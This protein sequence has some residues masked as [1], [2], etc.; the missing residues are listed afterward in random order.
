MDLAI[1]FMIITEK[2]IKTNHSTD[3]SVFE[4]LIKSYYHTK[5]RASSSKIDR[6]MVIL[7]HDPPSYTP[8]PPTCDTHDESVFECFLSK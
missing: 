8:K 6:V 5:F 2:C 7:V 1:K 4:R 3:K